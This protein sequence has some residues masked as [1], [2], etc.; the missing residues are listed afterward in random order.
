MLPI[1]LGTYSTQLTLLD[2]LECP[3]ELL[4]SS[5][6]K[7]KLKFPSPGSKI[8]LYFYLVGARNHLFCL[9]YIV[10]FSVT[11]Q[12]SVSFREAVG[13]GREWSSTIP[14]GL[15]IQRS[16]MFRQRVCGPSSQLWSQKPLGVFGCFPAATC[17]PSIVY[18]LSLLKNSSAAWLLF[19]VLQRVLLLLFYFII[20]QKHSHSGIK[21]RSHRKI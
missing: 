10:Q 6:Y 21:C 14:C 3:N 19:L 8:N 7:Y 4:S 5:L 2:V 1:R 16:A 11:Q 20:F 17:F 15:E 18:H 12:G 13:G 9:C